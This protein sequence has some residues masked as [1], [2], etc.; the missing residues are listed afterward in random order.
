MPTLGMIRKISRKIASGKSPYDSPQVDQSWE[1]DFD[2]EA[3]ERRIKSPS[4]REIVDYFYEKLKPLGVERAM[5]ESFQES[6]N[7]TRDSRKAEAYARYYNGDISNYEWGPAVEVTLSFDDL[8]DDRKNKLKL[9]EFGDKP[10]K[11]VYKDKARFEYHREQARLGN[12]DQTPVIL[13]KHGSKYHILEGHHRIMGKF[14]DKPR[15]ERGHPVGRI[16]VLAYVGKPTSNPI[17]ID[18]EKALNRS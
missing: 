7:V 18:K 13:Q 6:V 12:P 10:R 3:W 11:Y 14:Y 9:M 5:L 8:T 1:G 17:T 2:P 15:D 4:D 16:T